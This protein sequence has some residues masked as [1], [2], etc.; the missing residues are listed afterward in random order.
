MGHALYDTYAPNSENSTA[1]G[2][3]E[4]R[5]LLAMSYKLLADVRDYFSFFF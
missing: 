1:E 2:R 5:Q 4:M 3:A